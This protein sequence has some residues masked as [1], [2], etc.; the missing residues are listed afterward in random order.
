M[1]R[2]KNRYLLI[3]ILSPDT[4]LSSH[5]R[6]L[7]KDKDI[8]KDKDGDDHDDDVSLPDV[9]EFH[10]PCPD[11]LDARLFA[12]LIR[13]QVSLLYGDY[14]LGL[15]TSS[16]KIVYLSPATSTVIVKVARDHY[17]LVWAAVSL[18]THLPDR[19]GGGRGG[20]ALRPCVMR[21]VRVSGTIKKAEE[22]AIKRARLAILRA[23]GQVGGS[24]GGKG[25]ALTALL[26]EGEERGDGHDAVM[27]MHESDVVEEDMDSEGD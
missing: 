10:Q 7:I 8:D 12:R 20:G 5:R 6:T 24:G 21:V 16:L 22:E 3:H 13:E 17:R 11:T 26:G 23:K 27:G 25:K 19:G 18:M 15:I 4:P 9:V 14:G 2:I 1:V